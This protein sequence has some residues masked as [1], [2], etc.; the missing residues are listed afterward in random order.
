[1]SNKAKRS[2]Y[3]H[4]NDQ[5]LVHLALENLVE[6]IDEYEIPQTDDEGVFGDDTAVGFA[7]NV[8]NWVKPT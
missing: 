2:S 5:E 7:R 4:L 3:E 1:M 8:L 6:E